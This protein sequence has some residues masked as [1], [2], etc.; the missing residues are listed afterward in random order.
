MLLQQ[1]PLQCVLVQLEVVVIFPRQ[2]HL[3]WARLPGRLRGTGQRILEAILL[4]SGEREGGRLLGGGVFLHLLRTPSHVCQPSPILHQ[5]PG[6]PAHAQRVQLLR[7]G[8]R[9]ARPRGHR[10]QGRQRTRCLARVATIYSRGPSSCTPPRGLS[11]VPLPAGRY[12]H[13]QK[14]AGL[15]SLEPMTGSGLGRAPRHD[16]GG[17]EV[18][19]RETVP[20]LGD[21]CQLPTSRE[22]KT[23]SKPPKSPFLKGMRNPAWDHET[24]ERSEGTQLPP[25]WH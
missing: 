24:N 21:K 9:A 17:T 14:A 22:K 2:D 7:P 13:A 1:D 10:N 5:A 11:P 15:M 12:S 18:M 25:M 4:C 8:T 3:H 23:L 20:P 6:N 19:G 16:R